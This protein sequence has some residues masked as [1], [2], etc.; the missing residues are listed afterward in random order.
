MKDIALRHFITAL[1]RR[2]LR[3]MPVCS[4]YRCGEQPSEPPTG[5]PVFSRNSGFC[6]SVRKLTVRRVEKN[7]SFV[8]FRFPPFAGWDWFDTLFLHPFET[9]VYILYATLHLCFV[10][11]VL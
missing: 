8:L 6:F 2:G 11:I 9:H 5:S 4:M 7:R 1:Q 10:V 3:I